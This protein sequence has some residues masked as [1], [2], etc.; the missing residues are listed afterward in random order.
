MCAKGAQ[1]IGLFC[2]DKAMDETVDIVDESNNVINHTTK[3][4]A[5]AKGLLHRTV[6]AEIRD[7]EG[8]LTLV[9]QAADRQDPGQYVSPVG[10]H[11]RSGETE[12]EALKREAFEETGLVDFKFKYVGKVIYNRPSRGHQENHYFILYEIYT[13]NA[14]VL[15][16]ESVSYKKFSETELREEIK[17]HPEKF[18]AAF[19]VILES[20]YPHLLPGGII[21]SNDR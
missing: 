3:V 19:Y 4:D 10:G 8:N 16:E 6:I 9:E 12:I 1:Q 21:K 7:T 13:D 20:F 15:N 11:V 18:G 2:Y 17:S 5:H 14:L